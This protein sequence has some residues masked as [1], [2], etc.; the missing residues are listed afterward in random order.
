[1]QIAPEKNTNL[2]IEEANTVHGTI[3]RVNSKNELENERGL[4][5]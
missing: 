4:D 2:T 5:D 1:M 3:S